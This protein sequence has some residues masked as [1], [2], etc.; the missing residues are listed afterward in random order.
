M[1]LPEGN[2]RQAHRGLL[3]LAPGADGRD[4]RQPRARAHSRRL[5]EELPAG[6]T[7]RRQRPAASGAGRIAAARRAAH[8]RQPARQW[9]PAAARSAAAG[10]PRLRGRGAGARRGDRRVDPGDGPLPARCHEAEH[11]I[12]QFPPV[13]PRRK[14]LEPLAGCARRH[15]PRLDGGNHRP[16]TTIS[17][18]TGASWRCSASTS[19]RAG[20]KAIC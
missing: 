11:G 2:R 15:Q 12:A 3:A 8:E 13:Q 5:D 16:T 17:P 18:P 7:V 1:D 10:F 19:A 14:Q 9:R 4:A 20:S 6:G